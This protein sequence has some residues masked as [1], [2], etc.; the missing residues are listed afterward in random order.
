[1]KLATQAALAT[2]ALKQSPMST[3]NSADHQ[4]PFPKPSV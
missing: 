3:L 4:H 1:M 2:H